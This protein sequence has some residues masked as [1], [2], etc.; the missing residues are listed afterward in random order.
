MTT[1]RERPDKSD[2]PLCGLVVDIRPP[3]QEMFDGGQS[4]AIVT[5]VAA[6]GASK[7][8]RDWIPNADNL[9]RPS[10]GVCF[11]WMC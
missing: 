10:G 5:L 11:G 6:D 4:G 1:L 7:P 9:R 3:L 2:W 8:V